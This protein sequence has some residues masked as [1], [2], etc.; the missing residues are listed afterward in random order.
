M[1]LGHSNWTGKSP[2]SMNE[3]FGPSYEYMKKAEPEKDSACW[4][5]VGVCLLIVLIAL[6]SSGPI[7]ELFSTK[8]QPADIV[9][10]PLQLVH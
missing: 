8:A 3:A 6:C 5:V 1:K 7:N 4:W 9:D 10:P 2:R